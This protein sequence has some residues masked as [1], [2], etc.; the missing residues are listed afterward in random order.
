MATYEQ[1]PLDAQ[2]ARAARDEGIAAITAKR[3]AD[4][5]LV[6]SVITRLFSRY[7][8]ITAD[9]VRRYMNQNGLTITHENVVGASFNALA[10]KGVVNHV[11]YKQSIAKKRKGGVIKVWSLASRTEENDG[12]GGR[13]AEGAAAAGNT[14]E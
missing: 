8:K 5:Q 11:G 4:Y 12:Q 14:G 13:T 1:S 7:R 9:D 6:V 3:E 2:Q 10:K